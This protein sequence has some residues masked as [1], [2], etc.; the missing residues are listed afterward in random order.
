MK[1]RGALA[2]LVVCSSC[3]FVSAADLPEKWRVWRYSRAVQT[4][5]P[6]ADG[7]AELTLPWEIFAHC[8]A[9]CVDVR[10]AD[11]RGEEVPYVITERYASHNV[12]SHAAR[13]VE[14]SFVAG[15]YTQIIADLEESHVSYNRVKVETNRP[16][17]IVWAEIALSDDAKT[18]RIVE[19]RAPIAR[20]R[21][22]E[23]DGTQTIP[24]QALS[25]RYIRVRVAEP[26]AKFPVS[27]ISVLREQ[28][29]K[30]RTIEIPAAFAAERASEPGASVWRTSLASPNQP[31][32]QL[33]IK[34]DSPEFYRGVRISGSSDG[35]QWSYWGS[36]VIY[37]YTQAGKV[38]ESLRVEFSET[39]GNRLL[40]VEVINGN[41]QPLTNV[42]F[43]LAAVPRTLIF[44][45]VAGQ[46]YR[47]LYGNEKTTAPQ[48]DL[49]R[50]FDS[51]VSKPV[52]RVLSLGPEDETANY[53]D[54]RPFTERHPEVLWSALA[55]AI[56]LIGLTALKT[57]RRPVNTTPQN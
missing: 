23:V 28:E 21:S 41:D 47:L 27:G 43:T 24:F 40:R 51:G 26:S 8:A 32:S 11:S 25:S 2:L 44:K 42:T 45:E 7:P 14:N 48:Y 10:L 49:G 13:I 6:G 37:R 3:W 33:E 46:S 57:L 4:Q 38:R 5:P 12:E 31:I 54:P 20:F 22:R 55:V 18:W 56:V 30:P 52:Y 39:A 15:E 36:G 19:P 1:A 35:K 9:N 17:F 16:D 53:R 29:Y 50:Y 34:T